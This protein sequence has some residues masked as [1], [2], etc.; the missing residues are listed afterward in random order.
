VYIIIIE[1]PRRE[2]RDPLE[3]EKMNTNKIEINHT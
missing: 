1:L 3:K 2:A